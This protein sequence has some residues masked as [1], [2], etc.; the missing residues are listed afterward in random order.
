MLTSNTYKKLAMTAISLM[1]ASYPTVSTAQNW[2]VNDNQWGNNYGQRY[3]N[4]YNSGGWNQTKEGYNR[5]IRNYDNN[6]ITHLSGYRYSHS[7]IHQSCNCETGNCSY[8]NSYNSNSSSSSR[9]Y[10]T[11]W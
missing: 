11:P 1:I 7:N 3:N 9:T 4:G 5:T 8:S 6:T 10:T 2:D